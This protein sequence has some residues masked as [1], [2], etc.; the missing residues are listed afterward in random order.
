[1]GNTCEKENEEGGT[2]DYDLIRVAEEATEPRAGQ[3]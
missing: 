3:P 1:M 2:D